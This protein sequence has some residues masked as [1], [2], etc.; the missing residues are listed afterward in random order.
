[1][2]AALPLVHLLPAEHQ[3]DPGWVSR[4]GG[5]REAGPRAEEHHCSL[6][7]RGAAEAGA[8]RPAGPG[9]WAS[10]RPSHKDVVP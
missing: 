5:A 7:C 10:Q 8:R 3:E 4:A 1:M 9:H 6:Q 2:R